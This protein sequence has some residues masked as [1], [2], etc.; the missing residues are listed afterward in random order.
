MQHLGPCT[1]VQLATFSPYKHQ[2][3]TWVLVCILGSLCPNQLGKQ[4]MVPSLGTLHAQREPER[5]S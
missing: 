1:M 5:S 4:K 2:D 3:S